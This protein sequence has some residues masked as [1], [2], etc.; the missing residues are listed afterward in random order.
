MQQTA[1]RRASYEARLLIDW[2]LLLDKLQFVFIDLSMQWYTKY[3][4]IGI[5]I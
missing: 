4:I 1:E 2:E 5:G 3:V